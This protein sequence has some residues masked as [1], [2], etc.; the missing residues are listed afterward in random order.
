MIK[1]ITQTIDGDPVSLDV[2][3]DLRIVLKKSLLNLTDIEKRSGDFTQSISLPST[4]TN[5]SYFSR[6]GNPSNVGENWTPRFTAPAWLLENDNIVVS[7]VLRLESVGIFNNRYKVSVYGSTATIKTLLGDKLMSDIDMSD[8]AYEPSDIYTSWSGGFASGDVI[9]PIHDFGFGWGLYKKDT[10]GNLT[11]Q[12]FRNN[13]TPLILDRTLPA[14]RLTELLERMFSDAGYDVSASGSGSSFWSEDEVDKIYVQSDN[15]RSEFATGVSLFSASVLTRTIVD[16]TLRT[17]NF[18]TA[19]GLQSISSGVFTAPID[20]DY[21]FDLGIFVS[22][23]LPT[24]TNVKVDYYKNGIAQNKFL[25]YQWDQSFTDTNSK[26][27]LTAGD[28]LEVKIYTLTTPTNSGS[29]FPNQSD[30]WNLTSVVKSGTEVDPSEHW[31][32]HKQIDFFKGI[33]QT[34][35]LIP[36]ITPDNKIRIDTFDYFFGNVGSRKDWTDKIDVNSII[37]SP[38]NNQLRDPVFVGLSDAQSVLNIN[39]KDAVG[40]SYGSYYE[41]QNIPNTLPQ[42][43][44]ISEFTPACIQQL[45]GS[46]TDNEILFAK[47]YETEDNLAFKAPGLQLMYYNGAR[48]LSSSTIKTSDS[49]GDTPIARSSYPFFSNFRVYSADSWA[50]DS[51]TLD[52]NFTWWTPPTSSGAQTITAPSEQGLFN[53]YFREMIRERYDEATKAVEF[54]AVLNPVDL[55]EFSFADMII[56][57]INNSSIGI[58]I[59]EIS[60]YSPGTKRAVKCKGFLTSYEG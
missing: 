45:S 1:L 8:W 26:F 34:F 51:D 3:Q 2:D 53:R 56:C 60:D 32:N 55:A 43:D 7:G 46:V 58:R 16:Q 6:W 15:P 36:W 31:V 21:Y 4:Q 24:A 35:N 5:D 39:F 28:T 59:T 42:A 10:S 48:T 19:A 37:M 47:Y 44:V 13:G 29:I 52:L 41:E 11:L 40:R 50:V 23:G 49:E 17:V 30:Y 14:F 38:I 20:G 12:D 57:K 9:F 27:T 33:I 22:P 54:K 18:G 25:P